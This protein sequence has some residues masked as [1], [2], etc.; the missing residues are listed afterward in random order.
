MALDMAFIQTFAEIL[1]IRKPLERSSALNI[2]GDRIE[3][4]IRICQHF[5]AD[6]FYEGEAGKDYIS[7]ADFDKAGIKIEFQHYEHPVYQQLYGDF[8]SHLSIVDLL[9][10][11]GNSSKAILMKE[12]P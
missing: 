1:E 9:F 3:R 11:H 8:I 10:N 4:L 5:G 12:K 6:V 7:A 2:S